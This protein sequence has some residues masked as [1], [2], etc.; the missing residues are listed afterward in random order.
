[1]VR[2]TQVLL[3]LLV[4]VV[5]VLWMAAAIGSPATRPVAASSVAPE[6]FVGIGPAA[7]SRPPESQPAVPLR[8]EP[9]GFGYVITDSTEVGD[10]VPTYNWYD[11]HDD[12]YNTGLADGN[13]TVQA[14]LPFSFRF[15]DNIYTSVNIDLNGYLTFGTDP[16]VGANTL[17]GDPAQ[18]NDLVAV[19]WDSLSSN[20]GGG[21]YTDIVGAPPYQGYYIE[22]YNLVPLGADPAATGVTFQVVLS[23]TTNAIIMQYQDT[24]VGDSGYDGGASATAGLENKNA[25]IWSEYCWESGFGG[26]P[27]CNLTAN[28]AVAFYHP[29]HLG[30]RPDLRVTKVGTNQVPPGG[31]VT[32]TIYYSNTGS[33][34][35]DN[36][37]IT[38]TLQSGLQY[39]SANPTPDTVAGSTLAWSVGDLPIKGSGASS[40]P[41]YGSITLYATAP[42][43]ATVGSNLLNLVDIDSDS[44]DLYT[45][46]NSGTASTTVIPGP[47]ASVAI[48]R[49]PTS[50]PANGFSTANITA[51][52]KDIAGNNVQDGTDVVLE[53]KLG[54]FFGNGLDTITPSTSSGVATTIFQAGTVT[55]TASITATAQG[56]SYPSANTTILLTTATPATITLSAAPTS[57][58]ADGSSTSIITA[59]VS[60]SLGGSASDGTTV[61]FETAAGT[62]DGGG[63]TADKLLAGGTV[64]VGLQATLA[65]TAHITATAGSL[66]DT[67]TVTLTGGTAVVIPLNAGWNLVSFNV[68][69]FPSD[70]ASVL[71]PL[72]SHLVVAQGYDGG[73]QSYYPGGSQNTLT[74]VDTLH[75]YWIKLNSADTLT[76]TGD[77]VYSSTT[78]IPLNAGWNLIGYLPQNPIGLG[79]AL[80][81]LGGTY[82]A[83]LGYDRGAMSYY[84]AMPSN[85]NT[86]NS[87]E[88]KRGYWLYV[89]SSGT[90]CYAGLGNCP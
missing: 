85:M 83:V 13:L 61:S 60:D 44:T 36:V 90:L 81:S 89:T 46:N 74:H 12:G 62:L 69:P 9:D 10:G 58:P 82:T 42:T 59:V 48:S 23:E 15:Y 51:T 76:V 80:S 2:L 11:A 63:L 56:G 39:S 24:T 53:T 45:G 5:L 64:T 8:A 30:A 65:G 84:A 86:L 71:G 3:A 4:A 67:I 25:R 1:M 52:V 66:S 31:T 49:S 72:G 38:D 88:P 68:T 34:L 75:G 57:I 20:K 19:M 55:G 47:P 26:G 14:I 73:G 70:T 28:L 16:R 78:A 79:S 27:A 33:R 21:V 32:Y 77:R 41:G 17:V 18:P 40:D 50:L 6:A 7:Q 35:A 29:D 54:H 22:W 43:T 87:L 37:F